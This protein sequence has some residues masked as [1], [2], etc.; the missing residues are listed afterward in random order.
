M[1]KPRYSLFHSFMQKIAASRPGSWFFSRTEHH[2]D[3]IF[4]KLSGGRMTLTGILSG[5]PVIVLTTTGAKTGLPRSLPV[6]GIRDTAHPNQFAIIAHNWGR[7]H[8]PAWYF[9]LK[10]KPHAS[11]SIDGQ[12]KTYIAREANGEEYDRFWQSASETYIGF[13]LYKQRVVDRSIPIM[14]LTPEDSSSLL[15]KTN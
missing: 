3:R 6:L 1:N 15:H 10:K 12:V 11:C 9:N 2:F 4:L 13:P 7:H 14:I 5:L 8:H